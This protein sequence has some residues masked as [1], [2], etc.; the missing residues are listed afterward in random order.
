MAESN[1]A[2]YT[3][4]AGGFGDSHG[5]ADA[6]SLTSDKERYKDIVLRVNAMYRFLVPIKKPS[7]SSSSDHGV[8]AVASQTPTSPAPSSE[9]R[10]TPSTSVPQNL[11]N[12][13]VIKNIYQSIYLSRV[14]TKV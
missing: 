8:A 3:H 2:V 12:I 13:N 11:Y 6:D 7:G 1:G 4:E 10:P 5:E 9:T 14:D